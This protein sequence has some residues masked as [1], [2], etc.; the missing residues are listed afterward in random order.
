MGGQRARKAAAR[1]SVGL[2]PQR[3]FSRSALLMARMS[4]LNNS[5]AWAPVR[6]SVTRLGGGT[7]QSG[8][9]YPGGLDTETPGLSLQSGALRSVQN[10]ECAVS[11]GYSRIAGYERYDGHA[12]P[13]DASFTL[14]QFPVLAFTPVVN[15]VITQATSWATGTVIAV[16][17]TPG[18]V[19]LAITKSSGA[20]DTTHVVSDGANA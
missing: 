13:S 7:T 10:F 16:S 1:V 19:Y 11:G 4:S 3:L 5:G 2:P 12:K 8:V 6:Y 18:S 17:T 20:F 14:I 9:S 15:D